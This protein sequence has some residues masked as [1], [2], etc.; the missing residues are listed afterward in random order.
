MLTTGQSF[1]VV[2]QQDSNVMIGH[3]T[4][5]KAIAAVTMIFL[6]A[7]TIAVGVQLLG[8]ISVVVS[9]RAKKSVFI[10]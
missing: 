10:T 9:N 4:T 1:N 3:S 2:T 5:M 7:T 8:L 6:P